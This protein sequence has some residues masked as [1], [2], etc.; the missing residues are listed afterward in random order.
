MSVW[1]LSYG[2]IVLRYNGMRA[3]GRAVSYGIESFTYIQRKFF[4]TNNHIPQK[5]YGTA[6]F[7][8]NSFWHIHLQTK[9]DKNS[10]NAMNDL[11][12]KV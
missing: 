3:R 10:V 2:V 6:G 4:T 1:V 11:S 9:F 5:S 8:Q 7:K 12:S